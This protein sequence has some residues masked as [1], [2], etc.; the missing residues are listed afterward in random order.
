MEAEITRKFNHVA[1]IAEELHE[2]TAALEIVIKSELGDIARNEALKCVL[3]A[4]LSV[5]DKLFNIF[6]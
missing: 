6:N 4:Q 2:V 3:R 5:V 1:N